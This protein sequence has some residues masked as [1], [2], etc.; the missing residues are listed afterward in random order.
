MTALEQKQGLAE[1]GPPLRMERGQSTGQ[2]RENTSR[3]EHE[4]AGGPACRSQRAQ[5][6]SEPPAHQR[7]ISGTGGQLPSWFPKLPRITLHMNS[8]TAWGLEST[9]P[10]F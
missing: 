8:G 3:R 4:P 7:S 5:G 9:P 6:N 10:G 1:G 2:R